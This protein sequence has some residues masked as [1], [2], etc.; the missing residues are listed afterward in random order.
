MDVNQKIIE[1]GKKLIE[2]KGFRKFTMDELARKLRISKKTIYIHFSSKDDLISAII[3]SIIEKDL[4][5]MKRLIDEKDNYVE[6]MQAV[7]FLYNIKM[8]RKQYMN[9]LRQFLPHEWEKFKRFSVNRR[10]YVRR[11]YTEGVE[12]GVFIKKITNIPN[13]P[14][15]LQEEHTVD[16]LI[17][18]LSAIIDQAIET[19]LT[20]YEFDINTVLIHSYKLI[21]QMFLV[22]SQ[23]TV[24]F[25]NLLHLL[26]TD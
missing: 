12:K 20:D 3:N 7:F 22:D 16:L 23:Q 2:L 18:L 15:K 13:S 11:I 6:K 17:F 5:E 25:P 24:D 26:K 9:E 1:E 4:T 19:D 10:D 14:M 8:L 21:I